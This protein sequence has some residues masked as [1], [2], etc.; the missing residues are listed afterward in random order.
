MTQRNLSAVS[1]R[2]I[3]EGDFTF[4]QLIMHTFAQKYSLEYVFPLK[5]GITDWE[6]AF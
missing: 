1:L 2:Q 3:K 4:A 6:R 5:K